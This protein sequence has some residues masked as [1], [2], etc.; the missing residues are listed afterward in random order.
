MR[1]AG[2]EACME[3]RELNMKILSENLKERNYCEYLDIDR[4][5]I[6]K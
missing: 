3:R 4:T 1:L 5:I 2:H 6:L